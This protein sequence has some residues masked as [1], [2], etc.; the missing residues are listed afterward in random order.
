[1]KRARHYMKAMKRKPRKSKSGSKRLKEKI[2]SGAIV[3]NSDEHKRFQF[4]FHFEG[5]RREHNAEQYKKR[6]SAEVVQ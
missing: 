1:M 5:N 3:R 6:K 4:G 2:A